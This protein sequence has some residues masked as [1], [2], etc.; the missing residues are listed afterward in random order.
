MRV[1]PVGWRYD[2]LASVLKYAKLSAEVTHNYPEGI[3][4]VQA[5]ASAIFL[6]MSGKNKKRN[7]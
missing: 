6:A 5:V 1:S 2:D 3:K 7:S 4:R